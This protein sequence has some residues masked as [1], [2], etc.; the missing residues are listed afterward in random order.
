MA[1]SSHVAIPERR[2]RR[3]TPEMEW[4][5]SDG[6]EHVFVVRQPYVGRIRE[7]LV[8]LGASEHTN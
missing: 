3:V 7:I 1:E 8:S 5:E 4:Q 2:N 6:P